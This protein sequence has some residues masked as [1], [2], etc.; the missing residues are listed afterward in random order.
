MEITRQK[1]ARSTTRTSARTKATPRPPTAPNAS[2]ARGGLEPAEI[3]IYV[4]GGYLGSGKT[5]LLKRLLAHEIARG[6]RPAVIMNEFGTAN[7]DGALLEDEHGH[8]VELEELLGGCVCCDLSQELGAQVR[9]TLR[10]A[11]G[12]VFVETTGLA[13]VGRVA[14]AVTDGLAAA[15]G[16]AGRLAAVVAVVDAPRWRLSEALAADLRAADM[17]V[18]NKVEGTTPA[19][20]AALERRVRRLNPHARVLRASFG[21]V[22]P[23]SILDVGRP[24]PARAPGRGARAARTTSGYTTATVR[25]QGPIVLR[26]LARLLRRHADRLARVKGFAETTCRAGL[27]ALHWVPDELEARPRKRRGLVLPQLVFI[28]RG[29]DWGRF[30]GA[31]EGCVALPAPTRSGA[32]AALPPP[33]GRPT[34]R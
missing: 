14:A 12:A 13:A 1:E 5:T 25:L 33:A 21:D 23:A 27:Q 11:R 17:V 26:R 8:D 6:A 4:L 10:A 34:L 32:A 2:T 29:M 28:G 3:P 24:R 19:A 20:V 18:L 15:P 16:T 22:P 7:V 31:L 9:A 30:V